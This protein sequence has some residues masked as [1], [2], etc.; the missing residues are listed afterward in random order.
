MLHDSLVHGHKH[1]LL[2]TPPLPEDIG[3]VDLTEN[4]RKVLVRRYVRRSKDGHPAES[5]E[6]MFWRVAYHVARV[7]ETWNGDIEQRAREYYHLLTTQM[8]LPQLTHLYRCR[9][10]IGPVGSLFRPAHCR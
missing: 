3:P 7:E 4:A 5:V 10:A 9:H 8:F 6:E 2:P 1:G